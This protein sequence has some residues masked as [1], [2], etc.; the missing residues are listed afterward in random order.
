M[1]SICDLSVWFHST[2]SIYALKDVSLDVQD[3]TS[4]VMI[5]ETGSGKSV[6]I[7]TILQLLPPTAHCSGQ[8]LLDGVDLLSMSQKQ[9]RWVRGSK[10]GYV[11]QGNGNAMNPL[12]RVGF[13]VAE[14]MMEHHHMKKRDAISKAIPLLKKFHLGAE[15]TLI[16][17]YPHVLSGGMRQRT[18]IAMGIAANVPVLFADEPTKGLDEMRISEVID[19]FRQLKEHTLLCVTHDLSFAKAIADR[20]VVM[21]TGMQMEEADADTFFVE[22]LHPYSKALLASQAESGFRCE[23]GFAP[24]KE[25]IPLGGCVFMSLCPHAHDRCKKTPPMFDTKGR[26]VRCWLYES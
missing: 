22:P 8:V 18:M 15:E 24:P 2:G 26:K 9:M 4:T 10:I 6:L 23:I 19:A 5:G 12:L 21:Y 7:Q 16:H 13:Q 17:V 20:I 14:P 3:R 1:I 25:R 11:P